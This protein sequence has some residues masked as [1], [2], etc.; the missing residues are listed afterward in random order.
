MRLE[1][2]RK[3]DLAVRALCALL[4]G[5]RLKNSE[6]ATAAGT[7]QA[8]MAQVMALL[9]R[10][11]WVSSDP[12]PTGGYRLA[13]SLEDLSML[14]AIEAIEGPTETGKCVLRGGPCPSEEN[15]ALHDAWLPARDALLQQLASTPVSLAGCV[16]PG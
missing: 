9:V 6:L 11:G 5:G 3:S 4:E 14:E 15:C 1:I 8:F 10:R 12:G 13:I 16:S 7:T 2:T